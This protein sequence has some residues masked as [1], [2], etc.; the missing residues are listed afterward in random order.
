M[1]EVD[2]NDSSWCFA[3]WGHRPTWGLD[4]ETLAV[5]V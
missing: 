1:D 3:W 2:L 5:A 4:R